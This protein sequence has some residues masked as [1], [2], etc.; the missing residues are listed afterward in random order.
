MK[1][2][3]FLIV[4]NFMVTG[5][6]L[7]EQSASL[8]DYL[9]DTIF[10]PRSECDAVDRDLAAFSDYPSGPSRARKLP[11]IEFAP[12]KA[13]EVKERPSKGKQPSIGICSLGIC[14]KGKKWTN[15]KSIDSNDGTGDH[16]R[17]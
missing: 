2:F 13:N 17:F 1:L 3:Q 16:E 6:P 8:N 5:L 14:P 11:I 10:I 4:E 12:P 15:Y 7:C 9:R